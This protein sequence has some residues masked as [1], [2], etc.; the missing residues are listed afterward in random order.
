M[1]VCVINVSQMILNQLYCYESLYSWSAWV[2]LCVF[3]PS[4]DIVRVY[5][6]G[7]NRGDDAMPGLVAMLRQVDLELTWPEFQRDR[8]ISSPWQTQPWPIWVRSNAVEAK[9]PFPG[10]WCSIKNLKN[11]P[12]QL[13]NPKSIPCHK[14]VPCYFMCFIVIQ[15]TGNHSAVCVSVPFQALTCSVH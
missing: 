10:P 15:N 7:R 11:K 9:T 3:T 12:H 8:A 4:E 5:P 2:S 14:T 13:L 6:L 1:I